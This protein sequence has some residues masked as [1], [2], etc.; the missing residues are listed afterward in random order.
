MTF[1]PKVVELL[2]EKMI[3]ITCV[4]FVRFTWLN[5]DQDGVVGVGG[6]KNTTTAT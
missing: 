4:D 3:E 5:K 1:F 2:D 6:G